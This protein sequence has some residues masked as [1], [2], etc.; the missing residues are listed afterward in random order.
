MDE[1]HDGAGPARPFQRH[2]SDAGQ[3]EQMIWAVVTHVLGIVL[4]VGLV[5]ILVI[6][7]V[8]RDE[9]GRTFV[10][11]QAVE[12]LNFGLTMSAALLLGVVL[13][14]LLV[15]LVLVPAVLACNLVLCVMAAVRVSKGQ[16][17]RFPFA[18]R[19]VR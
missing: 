16:A 19:P 17:W 4:P 15:G 1:M 2:D 9:A 6:R 12:A 14:P 13:I 3:R 18:L 8:N 7:L 10:Q 11:A 5:G